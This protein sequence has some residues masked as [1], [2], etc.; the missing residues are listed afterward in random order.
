MS[1]KDL[2]T[3][4]QIMLRCAVKFQNALDKHS[5][6]KKYSEQMARQLKSSKALCY[7]F[8]FSQLLD[9]DINQLYSPSELK[10]MISNDM[11]VGSTSNDN[12]DIIT[13]NGLAD[14]IVS[15]KYI[16]DSTLSKLSKEFK[17]DGY[18]I[19]IENRRNIKIST[20]LVVAYHSTQYHLMSRM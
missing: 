3:A 20:R 8:L 18:F 4:N 7:F 10:K 11:Q 9:L 16:T 17:R 13:V 12:E 6:P 15:N 19:H 14:E 2:L 1:E 5:D